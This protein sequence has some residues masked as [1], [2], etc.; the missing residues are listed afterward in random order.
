MSRFPDHVLDEIRERV[1]VSTVVGRK[2]TLRKQGAEFVAV[3]DPSITVNDGKRLWWDFGKGSEGGDVFD[4]LRKHEGR[5]FTEAVDELAREAGVDVGRARELVHRGGG[6]EGQAD[7]ARQVRG[8]GGGGAEAHQDGAGRADRAVGRKEVVAE[9]DYID[10]KGQRYQVVRTQRRLPD[11][12]FELNREGKVW[13]NFQ[14]RRPSPDGDGSWVWRLNVHDPDTGQPIEFMRYKDGWLLYDEQRFAD[15][16]L[17][18]RRK[19]PGVPNVT[20]WL[21]G[22]AEVAE[23]IAQPPEDQRTI[24]IAEGE[25]NAD[26]L[27]EWNLVVTTNSGGA[28]NFTAEQAA[29]FKGAADVVLL[30]DND[31]AGAKRVAAIAPLLVAQGVRPRVLDIRDHWPE[32]PPKGDVF[33]WREAGGTREQF[34]EVLDKAPAWRPEPYKSKFGAKVAADLGKAVRAYPWRIKSIV[35]LVDNVLIMGPSRSGKSFETIDMLMHVH[36]GKPFAG[37]KVVPG[38]AVYL[39]YE[40]ATGFENRLRAYLQHHDKKPSDLHSFAWLTRPPNIFASEDNVT[41]LADEVVKIAEG[42]R[43][44]LACVVV[45]THNAATRGSSEI[46]SDDMTKIM[47]RYD[48]ISRRAGAPLWIIGHTNAEGK[49]RGNEQF[50]NNIETAL[51]VERVMVEE[52]GKEKHEKRDDDGRVIRRVKVSKQREGDDKTQWEFV[53]RPV[54][55]GT[56]EDGDAITSMVSDSPAQAVSHEVERANKHD[57]PSGFSLTDV[58]TA[59][60]KAMLKAIDEHGEAPDASLKLPAS[61]AKVVRWSELGL[62]YKQTVPQERDE[63]EEKYRNKV[64][65]QLRRFREVMSAYNVIGIDAVTTAPA[66]PETGAA[67]RQ[68]H[69]IWPSGKRVVGKGFVWPAMPPKPRKA[70]DEPPLVDAATGHQISGEDF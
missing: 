62:V 58:N 15:W 20:H 3:E 38:G 36:D 11:G 66:N 13:K 7:Q 64:K 46:K 12:S 45:D 27:L 34:L 28:G 41:A 14:Q 6:R 70:K 21:Y 33:D 40:G 22:A 2:F 68:V 61:V 23:E 49:H 59:V 10:P 44:P 1:A 48:V 50:F 69:F 8:G 42:F 55:I 32:C 54:E 29:F 60:F 35:P 53:L 52:R 56:D 39:T 63:T 57:R 26:A 47:D 9:Y 5:T 30:R 37:H 65:A 31:E 25:K 18:E 16:R 4:F 19:W 17:K 24:L 51:L 43:L 67:A